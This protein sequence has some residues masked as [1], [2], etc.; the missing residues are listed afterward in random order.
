MT[1]RL[2]LGVD[3]GGVDLGVDLGGVDLGVKNGP[4]SGPWRSGSC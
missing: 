3:L 2:D 1:K 4:R